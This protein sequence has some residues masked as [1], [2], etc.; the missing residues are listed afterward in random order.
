MKKFNTLWLLFLA[1]VI[2]IN[3]NASLLHAATLSGKV[4]FKGEAP[5]VTPISFGAEKQ[6]ADLNGGKLVLPQDFVVNPNAS[7][8][9]VL[10]Y[11]KEGVQPSAEVPAQPAEIDQNGC[12]FI[13]HAIAVRVGQKVNIKNG[14]PVLHNIRN[15]SKNI[16]IFNIAQPIQGMTTTRVFDKPEVGMK[17]R[18]DVHF[19][20]AGYVHVMDHPYY[21]LT[22][23]DGSF[24]IENL[25]AGTYTLEAWHEK[26]GVQAQT[27]TVTADEQKTMDF[28]FEKV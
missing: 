7:L 6:C 26:L 1:M 17:L 18:C 12:M 5:A 13:P 3:G 23:E 20:M 21:A 4:N 24:K 25:P 10:V 11:I 15:E 22:G 9:W 19:W 27:I 16:K 8:K 2:V 14:D 28:T